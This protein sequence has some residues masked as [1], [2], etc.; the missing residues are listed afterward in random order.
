MTASSF[1]AG[2]ELAVVTLTAQ[3]G[4]VLRDAS[5]AHVVLRG[6]SRID[7]GL[8]CYPDDIDILV[9]PN[10]QSQA[11][12]ILS[13]AGY[14]FVP[15]ST[16]P[17]PTPTHARLFVHRQSHVVVDLHQTILGCSAQPE[18]VWRVLAGI[19]E[20]RC[21][22][23]MRLWLLP[24][25]ATALTLFLQAVQHGL[26]PERVAE[27]RRVDAHLTPDEH[28]ALDA[29]AASLGCVPAL[30]VSKSVL[31]GGIQHTSLCGLTLEEAL[32]LRSASPVAIGLHRIIAAPRA[33]RARLIRQTI[34]PPTDLLRDRGHLTSHNPVLVAVAHT[35][36]SIRGVCKI[37]AAAPQLLGVTLRVWLAN[38]SRC[39]PT[40]RVK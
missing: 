9:S 21:M 13:R 1:S 15:T 18:V 16:V 20:D 34:A 17:S 22:N 12:E 2:V 29:L 4:Q 5:I 30:A 33:D 27:I 38:R 23:D 14:A 26:S 32:R 36:R 25:Y 31:T 37:A 7:L 3:V 28:E 40:H 6:V 10:Q 19:S 8:P 24:R 11:S 35:R 39:R